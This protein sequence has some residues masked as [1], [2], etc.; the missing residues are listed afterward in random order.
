MNNYKLK[1]QYDGSG[2][3]G[4]QFQKNAPSIQQTVAD[5]I[6]IILKEEVNLIGSGR[7]DAGVHA[8]GQVA[9]FKTESEPEIRRFVHS[10]NSILPKDI[11][12]VSMKTAAENFH[13]RFDAKKR[14]YI[15]L[16][17]KNKSPFYHPYTYNYHGEIDPD[18]LNRLSG[19]LT[20]KHDFT[21][22]S[23]KNSDTKNKICSVYEAR[24]KE[25]GGFVVFLIEADRFLHGMVRTIAGTL[26]NAV[27]TGADENYI[28]E[29][30]RSKDR[31]AAGEAVPAQGLFLYKVRY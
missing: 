7:T 6:K 9:N 20:G 11:A 3:S 31:E 21:S 28:L 22:F 5:T 12:V 16:I 4:W 1:I 10:M 2:Y 25:T 24:W 19:L 30:L 15:Y 29:V 27:K 14:S 17:G 18:K 13:S 8:L 23:R 26:L